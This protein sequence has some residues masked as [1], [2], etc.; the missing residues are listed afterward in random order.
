VTTQ[1]PSP[2]P[3]YCRAALAQAIGLAAQRFPRPGKDEATRTHDVRKTLK[4]A[5]A[6]AR[7]FTGVVGPRAYAA[8][9]AIDAAR[10][11]V[12]RARDLDVLPGVLAKIDPP[13]EIR[14]ALLAAIAQQRD[15]ERRAHG[16]QDVARLAAEL[17]ALAA[18]VATWDVE[19][20]GAA[21]LLA[22]TRAAYR[23]ARRRGE[24]ATSSRDADALHAWRARVV[25]LACQ[26]A[27]FEPAWP[28]MM[29]AAARELHR[30]RA[31]LGDHNDLTMLAEFARG[32][33]ELT[34][35]R[36]EAVV[37]LIAKR[38]RPLERRA[39]Q[40]H[41]RLFVERPADFERRLAAYLDH[42]RRKPAL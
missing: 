15:E 2:W 5:A 21:P 4:G 35:E 7:L 10:R 13:A 28:A 22:A 1:R 34:P 26:L 36:A 41:A 25:E 17:G 3:A 42:P 29:R 30:L 9:S 8:L 16:R 39:A 38:L 19:A 20:A 32:R 37:A 6:L 23:A 18:E 12:G 31:A 27:V 40:L 33:P 24:A 14:A 11:R